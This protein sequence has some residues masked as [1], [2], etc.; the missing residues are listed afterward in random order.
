MYQYI[1]IK[2]SLETCVCTSAYDVNYHFLKS[3]TTSVLTLHSMSLGHIRMTLH[4]KYAGVV[5]TGDFEGI[6]SWKKH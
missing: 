1:P 4:V 3:Q 5:D 6:L 2:T